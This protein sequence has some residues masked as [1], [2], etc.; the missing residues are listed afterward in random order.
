VPSS[1]KSR[2]VTSSSSMLARVVSHSRSTRPGAAAG[3]A[4][5]S[6]PWTRHQQPQAGTA[7]AGGKRQR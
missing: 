4:V 1:T 5:C 3:Q 6:Q 2:Y 7:C